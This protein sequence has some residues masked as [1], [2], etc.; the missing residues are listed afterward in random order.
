[1]IHPARYASLGELL[2]DAFIQYKADPATI[3]LE[4]KRE[5]ARYS[6]AELRDASRRV[7]GWL[8][9][10]GLGVG[11]RVA[12]VA[13][14]QSGW[15]ISAAGALHLG[16]VLVPLDARLTPEE[17]ATL[18]AHAGVEAL[19]VDAHLWRQL[20][21][22]VPHV[23]VLS[24]RP[25]DDLGRAVSLESLPHA[26]P[27][28]LAERTRDDL[29]AI[30]YSSGTGGDP[31][32]CMLTHGNYLAQYRA[33]MESFEW[34]H[35]DRY[36]S[37]LPTNHAIDFMCGFVTAFAT[38]CTVVHQRTL[39]P[40]FIRWAMR[41]YRVCHMSV[42]P[43]V[44]ESFARTIRE[45]TDELSGRRKQAFGLLKAINGRLTERGPRHD[46]SR[47]LLKPIHD[48]FGGQLRTI[49]CGGAFTD[50]A[51]AELFHELG[52]NVAIGYGLTEATTVVT[53]NDLAPFRGDT[54]GKAVP[55]V[56]VRIDDPGPDGVGE[57][58]VRGPTVFAG[59]LDD[60]D[61]TAAAFEDGWLK[62]GDL[63]WLDGAHHLHLVGRR[64]NM[65]VT[66]GGKNIYPEDIESSFHDLDVEELAVFAENFIWP[67]QT[68]TDERLVAVVRP[69]EADDWRR[70]LARRNRGLPDFKRVS[71]VLT[72]DEAFPRTAS[73][74]VKRNDLA[75]HLR[76][77]CQQDDLL[78]VSPCRHP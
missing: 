52:I 73:L 14:N 75:A 10:Q 3:E 31:K 33:L 76:A 59:Y 65:I 23:L 44:L 61:Q 19:V 12:I 74:K 72:W 50:R 11:S 34:R 78:P 63:G 18:L 13:T 1:V 38:G 71:A 24:S 43:L 62:T 4:R 28:P 29:A 60:P 21:V 58:W 15:L 47:W 48:G 9:E 17:Q 66:A 26:E 6:Y 64:K 45:R 25:R 5:T 41:R 54:V 39:R 56:Q 27:L 67:R 35:G 16:C 57:V 8:H 40:E 30:V 51:T 53:L 36:L 55:G 42:V 32:G 68:M 20:K 2:Q 69:G 70:E 46:V 22:D 77:S 7:S 37:I 49:F